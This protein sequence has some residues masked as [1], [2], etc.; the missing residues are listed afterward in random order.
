MVPWAFVF[1]W[2]WTPVP[3]ARYSTTLPVT[4]GAFGTT[5]SGLAPG[6]HKICPVGLDVDGGVGVRGDRAFVCGSTVVGNVAVGTGGAASA[7]TWVAPPAA[8]PL[9]LIDRDAGVSA[10]MSDGSLMWFFGDSAEADSVGNFKYFVNNTAA[11][12]AAGYTDGHPRR[13]ER[14]EALS[15]RPVVVLRQLL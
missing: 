15:V 7:P 12:A 5:L 2:M 10:E 6:L 4:G 8:S 11:W 1:A 13:G 14:H 3:P 9:R